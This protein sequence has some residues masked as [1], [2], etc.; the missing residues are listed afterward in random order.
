MDNITSFGTGQYY[1]TL[2]FESKYAYHI[3][4]GCLHDIGGE[5]QFA[6]SGHVLP[7]SDQLLLFFQQAAAQDE[8]F[9]YKDPVVLQ[10]NDNFHIAGTYIIND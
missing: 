4:D 3:R 6:I 7:G 9:T 10:T 2:P 8:P 5:D 1:L